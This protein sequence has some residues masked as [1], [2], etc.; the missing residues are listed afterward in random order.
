M[1]ISKV[2]HSVG[3][4]L[5]MIATT[6]PMGGSDS[7]KLSSLIGDIHAL[8]EDA[9]KSIDDAQNATLNPSALKL[10]LEAMLPS[11][12]EGAVKVA[13]AQ[14]LPAYLDAAKSNPTGATN[15]PPATPIVSEPAT[16]PTTDAPYPNAQAD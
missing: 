6:I 3:D 13:L 7:L 1:S 14:L 4:A 16:M 9:A 11:L 8:A 10:Q 12:V 2:L 5:K 15:I